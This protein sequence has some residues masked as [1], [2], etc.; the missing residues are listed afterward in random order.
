MCSSTGIFI[1]SSFGRRFFLCLFSVGFRSLCPNM[2]VYCACSSSAY[3]TWERFAPLPCHLHLCEHS[4]MQPNRSVEMDRKMHSSGKNCGVIE[5][6][7]RPEI[8][9][10]CYAFNVMSFTV[11]VCMRMYSTHGNPTN[12]VFLSLIEQRHVACYC[13]CN[14][15][16]F[17]F[18]WWP[19]SVL[20]VGTGV[21][22][23]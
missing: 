2:Y 15:I 20:A 22:I 11:F 8:Q 13:C 3:T 19:W 5:L 1:F 6:E 9:K 12:E 23:E 17:V 10:Y 4:R 14:W 21:S 7:L 16:E 18:I